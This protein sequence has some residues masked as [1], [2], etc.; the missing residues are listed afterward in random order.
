VTK[1]Q[2]QTIHLLY[3]PTLFCNLGCRYCYL[4]H[5]ID[6]NTLKQDQKNALST[7]NFALDKLNSANILP[8]NVSLHG[9]EVTTLPS[10]VLSDLFQRIKQ[11]YLQHY[12][13]LSAKG[14]KKYAPHIKTN[15]YN[16]EKHY[17]VLLKNK[18]SIS[19]SIDLPL[20]L[21]DKYRTTKKGGSTLAHTLNNVRLLSQYPHS[22]KISTTLFKEHLE[23]TQSIID[24]IWTLQHEYDFDM[25]QFN[26]MFGFES[27]LNDE[28][29]SFNNTMT[30]AVSGHQQVA[31]FHTLKQ[32]FVGTELEYGFK[33][34]WFDEFTP[35]YC[36]NATN[37]GE[38]FFLLQSDGNIYSCVRGQGVPEFHY[39]NIFEHTIE[40]ILDNAK[41]N[42]QT[43][44]QQHGL[45]EDC[46]Q[47]DYLH[48]C[49]TGCAFVKSQQN[50]GKSYTC[51][52]QK[53]LYKEYPARFPKATDKPA[54][55]RQYTVTIHPDL[56]IKNAIEEEKSSNLNQ[57]NITPELYRPENSLLNLIS[58]D[59]ILSTLYAD[60][61]FT[62]SINNEQTRLSSQLL[63]TVRSFHT[64]NSD[65][66]ISIHMPRSLFNVNCQDIYKNTL[67]IQLLRDT[68]VIY[69][70]EQR[71][72]QAHTATHQVFYHLLQSSPLLGEEYVFWSLNGLLNDLQPHFI[73][74]ILNNCFFT[75]Q[76]LREYHYQKQKNNA[77][78]HIQAINLPFQNMEF[79]WLPENPL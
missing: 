78:Y 37:C 70:D 74:N 34:H 58:H 31:F 15:L 16:F 5:Q 25:N 14:F 43:V 44:H 67:C 59:E 55:L 62:L 36:T 42:I 27:D 28:K 47:C 52:L 66:D 61:V 51:E 45:H 60:N 24:D 21:H 72:K 54:T 57:N 79:F 46:Q 39:G 49:H 53:T 17:D 56:A 64:L 50:R 63:K 38:R 3:V 40:T 12:D 29:Y 30:A 32:H 33:N 75:T 65:D 10:T 73:G 2:P 76:S 71:T 6:N 7:L 41:S 35:S 8:F 9:G 18:V 1:Q 4:G 69:G 11:H 22:K 48:L 77:F 13:V 68:P 26:V 20:K 23:N 19:A